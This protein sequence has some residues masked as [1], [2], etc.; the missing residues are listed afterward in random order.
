VKAGGAT[1]S[2]VNHE[3]REM[4]KGDAAG[5]ARVHVRAWQ[6]AYRGLIVQSHLDGLD[7]AERTELWAG[8]LSRPNDGP[9]FVVE[10][11]GTIV[12]FLA[13]RRH[14]PSADGAGEI[15]TIY[16]DPA[17]WRGGLGSALLVEGIRALHQ[18][19]RI[20]VILWV[21]E[22]N[23]RARRFYESHGW[24]PDGAIREELAGEQAA[25]HVRYR[26]D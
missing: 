16:L 12:G 8:I 4:S 21:L 1:V 2:G 25:L 14:S 5:V 3:I 15:R 9:R 22:G 23:E 10:V 17:H 24:R 19:V 18:P 11:D 26:L 13:G 7:V 6:E 20:P